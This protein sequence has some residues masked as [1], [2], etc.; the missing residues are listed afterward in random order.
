MTISLL[1][2]C[3]LIYKVGAI[4]FSSGSSQ[5]CGKNW[6]SVCGSTVKT[7]P[8]KWDCYYQFLKIA[9]HHAD[10]YKW[11]PIT[12]SQPTVPG[13]LRPQLVGRT[14]VALWTH[15]LGK[16]LFSKTRKNFNFPS[17]LFL[18]T[19]IAQLTPPQIPKARKE[20]HRKHVNTFVSDFPNIVKIFFDIKWHSLSL[21][22]LFTTIAVY[23]YLPA[24]TALGMR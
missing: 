8:Y 12:M 18:L 17:H 10:T 11:E 5:H 4:I 14:R 20:K 13:C 15:I 19:Q 22:N 9:G 16:G 3:L 1:R 21:W 7:L 23:C 6:S 2:M 24:F